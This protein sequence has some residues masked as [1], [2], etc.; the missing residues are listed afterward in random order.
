MA[1]IGGFLAEAKARVG[2]DC[3]IAADIFGFVTSVPNDG[4]IGHQ[5]ESLARVAD[6][7]S[8]MSYPNHWGPGWFGYAEPADNPGGVIE[9]S[10]RDAIERTAGL[11][12]LRP[13]LQDFGGYGP[14]QVRAQI[15]AADSLGLGW[16]L[17]NAGSRFT[18][19]GIPTDAELQTPSDLPA[20]EAQ[21]RPPSRFFDVP[22]SS[23]FSADVAWLAG[24]DI[25]RGCNPPWRDHYCPARG[26]TRAEA[27]SLLVR[28][29]DLPATSEDHFDDDDHVTSHEADIDAL[30]HAGIAEGCATD[31]F[32]PDEVLTRGEMASLLARAL[33]LPPAPDDAFVDDGRS[34]HEAAIDAL[35]AA[36]IT[37][38][39]SD[40]EFCPERPLRRDEA[41]AFL[42]R[43]LG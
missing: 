40:T 29:F 35:A 12:M 17:W 16:M 18:E 39:C 24:E 38:G 14:T 28:A 11:T 37:V 31:R 5:I 34:S 26:L 20:V 1:T 6:V 23:I 3:R 32:C 41:A 10:M 8:P 25:T 19:A 43:A 33:D 30:A 42:H 27:A 36:G 2:G 9:A 15:E 7:L 22:P 21:L 4:G 13:W